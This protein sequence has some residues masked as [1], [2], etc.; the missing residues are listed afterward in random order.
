MVW[1]RDKRE[2]VFTSRPSEQM[3]IHAFLD[4]VLSTYTGKICKTIKDKR[5][6][7]EGND[8]I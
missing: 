8:N 5:K 3:D 2:N 1:S 6:I 4:S 7:S